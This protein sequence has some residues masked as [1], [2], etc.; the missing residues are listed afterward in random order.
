[1]GAGVQSHAWLLCSLVVLARRR[2]SAG[3]AWPAG[4]RS[5][6]WPLCGPVGLTGR[7]PS[8]GAAQ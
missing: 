1:M 2:R 6:A 5:G 4:T 3:A 7:R 8:G